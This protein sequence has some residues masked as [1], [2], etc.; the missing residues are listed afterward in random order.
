MDRWKLK[1]LL[2]DYYWNRL[3][4]EDLIKMLNHDDLK[5]LLI[6]G[7]TGIIENMSSWEIEDLFNY[8]YKKFS[9]RIRDILEY[10]RNYV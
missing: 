9:V 3:S 2:D 5:E 4:Y 7:I 8:E 1:E 10:A 6:A